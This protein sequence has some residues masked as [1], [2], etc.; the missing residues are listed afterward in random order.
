MRWAFSFLPHTTTSCEAGPPKAEAICRPTAVATCCS[1]PTPSPP[2]MTRTVRTPCFRPRASRTSSRD[3][4][5]GLQK[6][7][8]KGSPYMWIDESRTPHCRARS[9]RGS[10]GTNTRSASGWNHIGCA[11][12]RSVTTVTKGIRHRVRRANRRSAFIVMCWVQGCN[13]MM[14]SGFSSSIACRKMRLQ[15]TFAKR[16]EIHRVTGNLLVRKKMRQNQGFFAIH[17]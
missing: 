4:G 1:R 10:D 2:P 12:P 15:R 11:P 3:R 7:R 6:S 9:R 5:S 16:W 14:R 13:E 8:R 17:M